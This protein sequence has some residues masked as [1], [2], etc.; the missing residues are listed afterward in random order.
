MRATIKPTRNDVL[1]EAAGLFAE[2]DRVM[3][4]KAR[5]DN[6]IRQ[7]CLRYGEANG[8]WGTRP[9]H[10]RNDLRARAAA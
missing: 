10:V 6:E 7:L 2:Y 4:E 3:A 5:L 1:N 8:Q 9:E